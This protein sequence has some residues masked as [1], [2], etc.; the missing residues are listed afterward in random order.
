MF[1]LF[2]SLESN[3]I[4]KTWDMIAT[5]IRIQDPERIATPLLLTAIELLLAVIGAMVKHL[6][7]RLTCLVVPMAC[8]VIALRR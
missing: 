3:R 7:W 1:R 8:R 6:Y 4:E 2:R 5:P